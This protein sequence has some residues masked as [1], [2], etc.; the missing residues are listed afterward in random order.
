[1]RTLSQLQ[2]RLKHY[3]DAQYIYWT[4]GSHVVWHFGTGENVELLFLY[5]A[6]SGDGSR[7]CYAMASCM[8]EQDRTPYHSVYAFRRADNDDGRRFYDRLGFTQVDLGPSVYRVG[9]TTLMWITWA[10]LLIRLNLVS[11]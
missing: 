9:G 3:D 4:N 10:D 11:S 7:L 5:S 2:D 6:D 8:I 1:M